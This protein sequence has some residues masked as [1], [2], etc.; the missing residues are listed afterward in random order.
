MNIA[1]TNITADLI[2]GKLDSHLDTI[3]DLIRERKR[4]LAVVAGRELR[5]GVKVK[6]H[7]WFTSTVSPSYLAGREVV[8]TKVNPKRVK[9][10]LVDGAIGRFS[11]GPINCPMSILTATAPVITA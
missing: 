2:E 9:V 8:V 10:K 7:L 11:G 6:Q 5:R 3:S 4:I 1:S